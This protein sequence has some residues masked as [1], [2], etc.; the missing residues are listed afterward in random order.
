MVK[1][2]SGKTKTL[3]VCHPAGKFVSTLV[4]LPLL[5]MKMLNARFPVLLAY[6]GLAAATDLWGATDP[7][8]LPRDDGPDHPAKILKSKDPFYPPFVQ[9]AGL[10]GKVKI[11]FIVDKEGNVVEPYILESNNPW[12]ERPT[13]DAV[14]QWKF[15]PAKKGGRPVNMR[16][17]QLITFDLWGGGKSPEL[18][19]V[20]KSKN[21]DKL[22]PEFQ[23]DTPAMPKTTLFPVYPFEELQAGVEGKAV[24][25]Y[26]VGPNGQVLRANVREATTPEFGMAV[27]AMIDA[28]QFS[29]AKNKK[30]TPVYAN[31][32][33]EY[34]FRTNGRGD[35]PVSDE[36]RWI[37]ADLKK[38]PETIA[39]LQELDRPLKPLSRRPPVYPSALRLA[40][41]PGSA[42][43]EFYVDKNGDAQLPR[44]VSSTAP[45]FGYAAALAVATWRFESPLKK[46]KRVVVRAQIPVDFK[47]QENTKTEK[48]PEPNEIQP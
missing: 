39:S 9:R 19:R 11:E 28:W 32:A 43:I 36:A 20:V 38:K 1:A 29:P 21:H 16:C 31:N 14:L 48:I 45:E 44:V 5:I 2:A 22:P 41:Q 13:I 47:F 26:I 17:Q 37:L 40:G 8:Q 6:L 42:L 34:S 33:V 23:W 27:M 15:S 46:G 24:V 3:A 25:N 35:I 4:S 12:F 30:G 10:V 7:K 18:W